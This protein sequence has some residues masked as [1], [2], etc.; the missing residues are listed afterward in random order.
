VILLI[1][2]SA[3]NDG[4]VGAACALGYRLLDGN[5]TELKPIGENLRSIKK[6]VKVGINIFEGVKVSVGTD[7]T[8]PLIGKY[9]ATYTFGPQKGAKPQDL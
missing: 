1:G 5:G 3:T 8:S 4:G 2:G 9:G 6:I 7:V